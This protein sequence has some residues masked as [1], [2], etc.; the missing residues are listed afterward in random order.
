MAGWCKPWFVNHKQGP[1]HDKFR[2]M[3]QSIPSPVWDAFLL[4]ASLTLLSVV[5]QAQRLLLC[6]LLTEEFH[7]F[8]PVLWSVSSLRIVL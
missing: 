3:S 1:V 7:F 8:L 5:H 2:S 6:R 4:D